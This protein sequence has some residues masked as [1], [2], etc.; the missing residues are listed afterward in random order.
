MASKVCC[1]LRVELLARGR[2]GGN[3]AW[4]SLRVAYTSSY[5]GA[6]VS[7]EIAN[8]GGGPPVLAAAARCIQFLYTNITLPSAWVR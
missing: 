1:R 8:D 7:H 3:N 2:E 6:L 5:I 4:K